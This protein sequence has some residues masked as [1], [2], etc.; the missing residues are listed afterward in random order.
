MPHQP[1]R[2]VKVVKRVESF[3]GVGPVRR[4]ELVE[5]MVEA[6]DKNLQ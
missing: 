1:I 5:Y 2:E 6:T 4:D 3:E